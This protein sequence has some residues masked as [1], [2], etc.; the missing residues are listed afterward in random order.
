MGLRGRWVDAARLS[1]SD[2]DVSRYCSVH[3][4]LDMCFNSGNDAQAATIAMEIL[5]DNDCEK[6]LAFARLKMWPETL[7]CAVRSRCVEALEDMVQKCRD[8]ELIIQ[9]RRA[10]EEVNQSPSP[11][12]PG[13][14]LNAAS[15]LVGMVTGAVRGERQQCQQQ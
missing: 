2:R 4:V 10:I 15:S 1:A 5:N 14:G 6:A 12:E 3:D 13:S 8:A 7:K 11:V 9:A